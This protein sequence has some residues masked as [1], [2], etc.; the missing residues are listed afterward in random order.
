MP[1]PRSSPADFDEIVAFSGVERFLDTPVKRY[2]S[3][4]YLRLAFAVAAH[5]ERRRSCSST[6]CSQSATPSSS[7]KLPG[8]DGDDRQFGP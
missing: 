1:R 8:H 6:R 7:G 5:I 4:M 2:S 3:G